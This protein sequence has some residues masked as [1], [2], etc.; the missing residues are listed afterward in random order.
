METVITSLKNTWNNLSLR[1]RIA[2]GA[3]AVTAFLLL[4]MIAL[5]SGADYQ[6]LYTNLELSDAAEI[7]RVLS[8][9]GISYKLS[10]NGSTILVPAD[11]VYQTRLTLA[12]QGLPTGG[13]VGFET[14][15]TTRLGETEADRQLRYRV[16]LEGE[17][18]RTIRAI[19]EIEDARVHLVIPPSSL[20]IR[21]TQPSTASV[22]LRLKP[23][24][25]LT[26]QQIRGIAHLI[27]TSVERLLPENITIVDTRGNVL[28][29]FSSSDGLI[30][31]AI[32]QQLELKTAYEQQLA[33]N[34]RAML[35]R[36]YGY[37][38][39]VCLVNIELDFDT[40]ERYQE[41]YSAPTR[42]GG[43]I[44]SEQTFT[45]FY[46]DELASAGIPG[47]DANIP[48]YVQIEPDGNGASRQESIINY[49]LN[50]TEIYQTTPAGSVKNMSVSIW[51]DGELSRTDLD[52]V[53]ASVAG[54]LG[55][56]P[57]RG[58]YISV[59][60]VPFQSDFGFVSSDEIV[61]M[62]Y[63]LPWIYFVAIGL[64]VLILLLVL[65]R[66]IRLEKSRSQLDQGVEVAVAVDDAAVEHSLPEQEKVDVLQ[67]LRQY[68]ADRPKDFAQMIRSWLLDD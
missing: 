4:M 59:A 8:E 67:R 9:N 13:V 23:G 37:G 33:S 62:G 34:I 60:S 12:A 49:E 3:V 61:A 36:V 17:L 16:A 52:A 7:T 25:S 55:I 19:D 27:A 24:R 29:D 42:D 5:F 65:V 43:L 50:R 18:T 68:S 66:H 64:L 30:G 2:G 44:R 53:E 56:K 31:S 48:G 51:I 39:V 41:I 40:I 45:E 32:S 58:D 28:H 46:F 22:L 35:E 54:A 15:N 63:E 14:F 6:P 38:K 20:F 21:E 57:E 11:L 1:T 10:D 26:Q 47:V